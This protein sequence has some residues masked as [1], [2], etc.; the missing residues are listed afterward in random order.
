MTPASGPVGTLVTVLGDH[1]ATVTEVRIG[2]TVAPHAVVSDAELRFTVH[3][4]AVTAMV[5]F[6]RSAFVSRA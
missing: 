2:T 4:D 5:R 1:L 6:R 3:A